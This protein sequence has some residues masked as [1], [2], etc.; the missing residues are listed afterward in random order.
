M[1]AFTLCFL[2]HFGLF[3]VLF[4]VGLDFSGVDGHEPGWV[5]R[6]AGA[7]AYVLG[8][9]ALYLS[10]FLPSPSPDALEWAL[11]VSNSLLW[12]GV[13]SALLRRF[14]SLPDQT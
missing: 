7:L 10:R 5:S 8:Q 9:P 6:I 13:M 4:L 2:F 14:N 11:L 3:M 1:R 12:A